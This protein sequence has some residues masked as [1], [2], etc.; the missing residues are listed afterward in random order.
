MEMSAGGMASK[1]E[2]VEMGPGRTRSGE[3]PMEMGLGGMVS[4]EKPMETGSW[5]DYVSEELQKMRSCSAVPSGEELTEVRPSCDVVRGA[6]D[7]DEY[8]WDHF[9]EGEA[10]DEVLQCSDF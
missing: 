5:W 4:K 1:E 3:K 2:P 7:G 6:A 9:W 8:W 10:E